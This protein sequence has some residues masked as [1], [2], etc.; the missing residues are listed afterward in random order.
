MKRML[1]NATQRE[2]LRVAIV[3]GQN[4]YDLDIEIPSREQKKAN[5]Y[6]GR[7]TRVEP[8]LEAC[9]ID[10]GAERHGFLPLKEVSREYFPDGAD[11]HKSGIRNLLKE[12]QELIVQ[13]EKEE[14]G[15]KGAAL[16]TYISLAGRYMVLMPNNPKAGGVSRRIEG[17]DRA[18]LKEALEHLEVPDSMGLIVRTAG[19]GRSA[20]ELQW[21]LDYLLQLW[22]SVSTAGASKKA[23]FLIYQESRLFIRALR[24]YLRGDIGEILIDEPAMYDEAHE[25]MQQVMPNSLRKLKLY[26]DTTP[27][28]SRFQIETQIESAFDR[29]VRLPAGGSIVIDPTEAL[30]S[31]DINSARATK[32]SD[33]EE[34][35]FNTNCEAAVEIARQLRIRDA[36]GLI[37]IDFIDMDSPKH[38]R[39][40]EETLKDALKQ[41]RARVQVGRI[42][43]F[44]LLEMSRQRLRPSLGEST[45]IVCPR[46]DGHG[47]I[48]SVESLSLSALR[49]VEEHAMKENTGQVLIQAPTPVANFLLNEKRASVVEIEMR[50]KVHVVIVADDKLRT[51][52]LEITRIREVD[53]G[54]HTKPSYARLTELEAEPLRKMGQALG[55]TEEPLVSRIAHATPA[56][57]PVQVEATRAEAPVAA[58]PG[59]LKR[60]FGFL[61][62]GEAVEDKADETSKKKP[63]SSES[64]DERGRNRGERKS[65]SDARRQSNDRRSGSSSRNNR[66]QRGESATR[67]EGTRS[68][69]SSRSSR[70]GK[71]G[72]GR[73]NRNN[74]R[75]SDAK[76]PARTNAEPSSRIKR[77]GEKPTDGAQSSDDVT[78]RTQQTAPQTTTVASAA[79]PAAAPKQDGSTGTTAPETNAPA[80]S[81]AKS[82]S[83]R[84]RRGRRGGRRRRRNTGGEA[85][86]NAPTN[87]TEKSGN[88]SA[89]NAGSDSTA[90][91]GRDSRAESAGKSREKEPSQATSGN[92]KRSTSPAAQAP[93]ASD[94]PQR[95]EA[96]SNPASEPK[97]RVESSEST[98]TAA[99]PNAE[100]RAP[101]PSPSA[102]R[103]PPASASTEQSPASNASPSTTPSSTEHKATA[104]AKPETPPSAPAKAIDKGTP[105]PAPAAAAP[106]PA[107]APEP[108][109][110]A[111]APAL[112]SSVPNKPQS[113]RPPAST[114]ASAAPAPAAASQVPSGKEER[115]SAP[116]PAQNPAPVSTASAPVAPSSRPTAQAPKP[117]PSEPVRS[118][119]SPK[120]SVAKPAEPSTPAKVPAQERMPFPPPAREKPTSSEPKQAP[121]PVPK[122]TSDAAGKPG[123]DDTP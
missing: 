70:G 49:L 42:S 35:A 51:P 29:T 22:K 43:R 44:G 47:H 8:S 56:P 33:I 78:K 96:A 89:P 12:G 105:A 54:E 65:G 83:Q 77:G 26:Q 79:A 23:P 62:A 99:Q 28:F 24:D 114:P 88:D 10:Y 41:D 67:G 111:A 32:G 115:A 121:A 14:R 48:R 100:K 110:S 107:P 108:A 60:L 53:M 18:A 31:I 95:K 104:P 101:A 87:A 90:N 34:T 13:V 120:E 119:A 52:H 71:S 7:I 98:T 17:E 123:S 19:M 59:L 76:S 58:R 93:S 80:D 3:D 94:T 25:F 38:Q 40:V 112:H 85:S 102:P 61:S 55:S 45:K 116:R 86:A 74:E 122:P 118:T 21:D 75:G 117:S 72:S 91:S 69:K 16:T 63:R 57:T 11:P 64:R 66:S 50:H 2:E 37:V 20:E 68:E 6:K 15:N 113:P 1:I 39:E 5:I 4:L 84:R 97:K 109:S 103:N 81:D 30:T 9:F 27:L 46:C 106:K 92:E 73:G 36:G 82:S